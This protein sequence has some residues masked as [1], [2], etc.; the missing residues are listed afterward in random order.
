MFFSKPT[1]V[2]TESLV[3]IESFLESSV[4]FYDYTVSHTR[5][6]EGCR[7]LLSMAFPDWDLNA[8]V[9]EQCKDGITNKCKIAN[10]EHLPSQVNLLSDEVHECGR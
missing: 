8:I 3:A 5:L 4:P 2:S 7:E 6:L 10:D 1:S 9:F